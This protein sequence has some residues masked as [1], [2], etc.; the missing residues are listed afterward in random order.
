MY[1]R[2]KDSYRSATSGICTIIIFISL[3]IAAGIIFIPI[4]T[5][6]EYITQEN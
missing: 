3:A 5:L 4:F 6:D 1:F 2:E